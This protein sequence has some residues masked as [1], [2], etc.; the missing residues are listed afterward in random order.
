M[1]ESSE[2]VASML[3]IVTVSGDGMS[4]N[5]GASEHTLAQ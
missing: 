4:D 1:D 2:R 3:N 5:L